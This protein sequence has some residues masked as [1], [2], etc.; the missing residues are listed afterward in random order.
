[1]N[2]LPILDGFGR[3][4]NSLRISVTD[5]CNIRCFY[6]MPEHARFL[7][8]Q[9]LLTFEEIERV[10][11]VAAQAGVSKIR[12]T[13]GEPLVRAQLWNL[14]AHL[15][16][17]P[18]IDDVALTTNGLLLGEQAKALKAAGLSRL[19]VSLDAL[20]PELFER[21][22][23]RKGLDQVLAGIASAQAAGFEQ[24]RINAVSIKG[25]TESEVV[26]LARFSRAHGLTLRFIEFMPLD[27]DRNWNLEQVLTGNEVRQ[28]IENEVCPLVLAERSNDQQPA[29]D[30]RYVDGQGLVGFINSVSE[31]FCQA[32]NRMRITAEGKMRNCLFS[33]AEWDLRELLRSGAS[34]KQIDQRIRDCISAKK[35]GHGM[36]AA[37]FLP[38]V[39]AMYQI[40]G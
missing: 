20:N 24:I 7:P 4:H 40:G 38:P 36:D 21:I 27:A 18:G 17:V 25:L 34:V 33:Q 9:E 13:G 37:D 32:C 22:A 14:I 30:F 6:C 8:R 10:V 31:P 2:A 19:N 35:A 15:V 5:R 39:R 12:L 23:R 3:V 1:M 16:A 26:P 11:R 28:I 29:M